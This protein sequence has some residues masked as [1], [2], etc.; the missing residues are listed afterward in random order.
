MTASIARPPS[1]TAASRWRSA[2]TMPPVTSSVV[3]VFTAWSTRS[4]STRTASVLVPP[5]S[6]P[7]RR[8][9]TGSHKHRR[10]VEVVAEGPRT[11]V[12]ET[13]R[14]TEH[15]RPRQRHHRHALAIPQE[16]G[17]HR[18]AGHAVEKTDEIRGH[19]A[20]HAVEPTHRELV[21]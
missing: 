4:S 12:V 17:S 19:H 10:E 20:R 1:G 9:V 15:G 8:R 21:L 11:D 5:T 7:M 2:V 6:M 13:L 3:G 18:L 14:G 16:L